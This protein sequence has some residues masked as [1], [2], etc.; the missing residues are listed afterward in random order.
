MGWIEAAGR[1]DIAAPA[2]PPAARTRRAW[3]RGL[4]RLC[5]VLAFAAGPAAP[6]LAQ[7]AALQAAYITARSAAVAPQGFA[8]L[9]GRYSWLCAVSKTR[10]LPGAAGLALA[11]RIN[12]QVNRSTPEIEDSAQY[13][14]RDYWALPTARGGDCEDIAMLKKERLVRA[15]YPAQDLMI[16]TVLDRSRQNHAVLVART[17]LG[18]FVLDNL[19]NT[20]LPWNSTGYTFITMQNPKAPHRWEAVLRGGL[21]AM[22]VASN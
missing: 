14:V 12:I 9:C 22:R 21:I 18:D 11:R 16:A 15:G 10:G 8:A 4:V 5:A 13:G 6:S 7:S 2:T 1:A 19:R 20:V 3:R 17:R